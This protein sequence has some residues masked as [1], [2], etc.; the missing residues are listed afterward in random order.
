MKILVTG[1]AGFLGCWLAEAL[2]D[3]GH[4]VSGVDNLL[5]G[6]EDNVHGK[7]KFI[8]GDVSDLTLMKDATKGVDV[9]YHL[10]AAP[11]EGLSVFS[12]W[13]VSRHTYMTTVAS[14]TAAVQN[15]VKGF[16]F[17]SSMARYGDA[18]TP[19]RED[20]IPKPKDPYGVCKLASE[21]FI[22]NMC[23]AHGMEFSIAAPH[24]I[25][26]AKQKYDDPYRNVVS[27]FINRMLQGKQPIIY[28]DGTQ[29]RTFSDVRDCVKPLIRMMEVP[30]AKGQV[31]NIGP[32]PDNN[33][34]TINELAKIVAGKLGFELKPIFVP[35]RPQEVKLATC[36]DE[37]AK[38]ILGYESRH[39]MSDTIDEMIEFIRYRGPKE[40]EYHLDLEIINDKT[41][42]TWKDRMF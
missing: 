14:V 34:I 36:S 18:E 9:V 29:K 39:S 4:E 31:I 21:A 35:D 10:A 7:V 20:M 28:G 23:A 26:G 8:R 38:K 41:P 2:V 16:V 15:K 3:D 24:N 32:G 25:I 42:K 37:K 6:Y 5:G 19:F 17:T 12:P 11:H 27:I 33:F 40:F 30:E 22:E 1:V 13:L